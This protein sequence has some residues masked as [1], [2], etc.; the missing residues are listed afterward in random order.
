VDVGILGFY[1]MD[2]Q[3]ADGEW[4]S[5]T[6]NSLTGNLLRMVGSNPTTSD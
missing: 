3:W 6:I 5:V 2:F 1:A 4:A